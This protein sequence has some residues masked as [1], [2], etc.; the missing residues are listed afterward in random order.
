MAQAQKILVADDEKKITEVIK[1][2][3]ERNGFEVLVAH[4]GEAALDLAMREGPDL[5]V[6]DLML[7]KKSG[8]EVC[9]ALRSRSSDIPI[10]MVTAKTSLADRIHGLDIGADDYLVKPFSPGELVAR[11]RAILRRMRSNH[12][13][14]SDVLTYGNGY[15]VI[16]PVKHEVI[17]SGEAVALT[18]T[19]FKL[20]LTLARNPGRVY[21]RAHLSELVQGYNY[22]GYD[23][24][25]Y[26]HVKNLR[27]KIEPSPETPRFIKTV[28]GVGYK[29]EDDANG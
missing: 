15:L 24:T 26:V 5:I 8:E 29:F 17:C 25:I 11:V 16:D 10:L 22:D 1:V 14:P 19:E 3:L 12:P 27:Q 2:Y 23:E 18:P 20:L 13:S 4:D 9:E 6:L 21:T 28:Y 7:P